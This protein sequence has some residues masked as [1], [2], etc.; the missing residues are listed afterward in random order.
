MAYETIPTSKETK[1]DGCCGGMAKKKAAAA[2]GA[3]PDAKPAS[4]PKPADH[5]KSGKSCC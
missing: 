4:D 1:S 3:K 2:V 5:K